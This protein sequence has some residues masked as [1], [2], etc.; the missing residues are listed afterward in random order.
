MGTKTFY[1]VKWFVRKPVVSQEKVPVTDER[2]P[3][4][5][6][7]MARLQRA[8][9]SSVAVNFPLYEVR[10]QTVSTDTGESKLH[11]T[12]QSYFTDYPEP[13]V[14]TRDPKCVPGTDPAICSIGWHVPYLSHLEQFMPQAHAARGGEAELWLVKVG[15]RHTP[16]NGSGW[17][18]G[19][20]QKAAFEYLELRKK[21]DL[22]QA[23]KLMK[24]IS[25]AV[26]ARKEGAVYDG[27]LKEVYAPWNDPNRVAI[28]TARRLKRPL[29]ELVR[30]LREFDRTPDPN[31]S[32]SAGRVGSAKFALLDPQSITEA[33]AIVGKTRPAS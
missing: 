25:V 23:L 15:G 31:K 28:E 18:A 2:H 9:E 12:Y 32:W 13:G 17:R 4:H 5:A 1:S 22:G 30:T 16:I 14:R 33:E 11:G 8:S 29:Q 21:L 19:D 20:T 27:R 10:M 6:T 7:V 3:E 24:V 26:A